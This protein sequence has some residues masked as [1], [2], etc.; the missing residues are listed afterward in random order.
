MTPV[1][2]LPGLLCDATLWRAQ[3]DGLA[4]MVAPMV[5]DLTLDQTVAGMA[6]RTLAAAPPRFA[7][8]ALSMGG[9]VAF[10]ILRQAPERVTGLA[11]FDTSA[12][13]DAPERAAGRH[14]AIESLEL[15][16]FRGV[17][18]RL[19]PQLVHPRHVDGPL[20]ETVQAMASRVGGTAFARQQRAILDRP[21]SRPILPTI[22][23]PTLVA[24]GKDDVLTPPADA[25][26]IHAGIPHAR[27]EV[28]PECGH[29]PALEQPERTTELIRD[30]LR[31]CPS[32]DRR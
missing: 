21:D 32:A 26:E 22:T 29:L 10:E 8:V 11:L 2:F 31:R 4:D 27:L 14:A 6:R 25:A 13:P 9:Y 28:L 5:A 3:I 19:L 16:R 1:L 18:S 17:T 23:V 15:G 12:A 30:L 24:V 7:L 20:A